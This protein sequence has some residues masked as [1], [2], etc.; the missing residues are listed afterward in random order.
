[1]SKL[2]I[3]HFGEIPID[4]MKEHNKAYLNR[5]RTT[6]SIIERNKESN[7]EHYPIR[8]LNTLEHN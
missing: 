4:Q 5:M 6:G 7:R 3:M 1:M 8:L 2:Q